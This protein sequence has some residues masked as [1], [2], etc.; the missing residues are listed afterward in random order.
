MQSVKTLGGGVILLLNFTTYYCK[1]LSID[2]KPHQLE[3]V[4]KL[5]E[6]LREF[7]A[8]M[9]EITHTAS[10]IEGQD[11]PRVLAAVEAILAKKKSIREQSEEEMAEDILKSRMSEESYSTEEAMRITQLCKERRYAGD[12]KLFKA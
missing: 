10:E 4:L 1:R 7:D 3:K 6:W 8:D 2:L 9:R 5:V 11:S 12:K